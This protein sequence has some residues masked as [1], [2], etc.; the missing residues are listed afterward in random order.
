MLKSS[1]N[2]NTSLVGKFAKFYFIL[3]KARASIFLYLETYTIQKLIKKKKKSAL[4]WC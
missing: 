4:E 3:Y 2:A 1:E